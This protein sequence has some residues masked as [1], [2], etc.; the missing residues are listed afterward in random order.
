MADETKKYLIN[1]EDNLDEY[2]KRAK[3]AEQAVD[4]FIETNK[5]LLA[6]ADRASEEYIKASAQLKVLQKNRTDASKTVENAVRI[7]N[8]EVGSYQ[9]L[10]QAWKN[11]QTQLK[12]M[13]NAF[14]VNANGVRTLSQ[15]YLKQKKV[16][17]DAKRG[18]DA[19]GKGVAD[20]R[21][22][23]GNYSEAIE[24]A[25]G[26]LTN[27]P[28]AAGNAARGVQGLATGFKAVT[29]ASPLIIITLVINALN[30][31][32]NIFKSLDPILEKI[33][34]SIAAIKAVFTVL[35]ESIV[36]LVT[37]NKSLKETFE[38]LG[39]A[40][41][42]AAQQGRDLKQAEQDL[43]NMNALLTV[44]NAKTKR[45][46][47]ELILQ[48]KDRTKTEEERIQLINQAL[49]AEEVQYEKRK[50]V[51]DKELEIAQ[52][53]IITGRNLTE[54]QIRLLEEQGIAYAIQLQK[55]KTI[56]DEEIQNLANA[57]AAEEEIL[58]E[59]VVIREKAINRQNAL[60]D[61]Q[62][63][64][65]Q[66]RIAQQEKDAE[67]AK[68]DMEKAK[69]KLTKE[70]EDYKQFIKDQQEAD[71]QA[72]QLKR[73]KQIEQAEWELNQ[74]LINQENLLAIREQNNE[75]YFSIERERLRMQQEAEIR[76][77][78][79]TGASVAIINQKYKNAQRQLD[80]AEVN[81]KL[82]LYAGFAG[83]L[84]QI[85]GENTAIGKAA[86]IAQTTIATY[87]SAVEA[88]KSLAGIPVVGPALGAVAA[89]AAIAAGIANVK[90]IIAVKSGLPGDTG[91]GGSVP[92]PTAISGSVP[93]QR[94]TAQ[95]VG[96]TVLTQP[97]LTQGQVNALPNQNPL[98]AQDIADA[99]S[100]IP[101][102]VV[103][104]EDIN[105]RTESVKKVEV[106]AT[107]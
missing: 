23:V 66:K 74:Q 103:T 32:K 106:R 54:E 48:S 30:G 44:S 105:A 80:E 72:R 86:A 100:K 10:Y 81:A 87:Q 89:G 33:E 97:T 76:S 56:S 85:F 2:A 41:A 24:G 1:V 91:G 38:G 40:M 50:E 61:K 28:G 6:S 70:L 102:P 4:R 55:T 11:A 96:S 98:T 95:Q 16:V 46:I 7:Q 65:R 27:L 31:L 13:P 34:R 77:A 18:L 49:L 79:D 78:E 51:A 60:L 68:Q 64:E 57:L 69:E 101:A 63:E 17:E 36:G 92:S 67:K 45:Q 62:E 39:D 37:G 14:T 93:A 5:D 20:N 47:D 88:F 15:E 22:N 75:D 35:R 84:A 3:E 82:S 26:K 9:Q 104:V 42:T 90:K 12:L 21:L 29:A 25:L 58:N 53:K 99:V 8:A 73:E 52:Q 107:I 83:N 71:E 94:L 59:S 19:F 43:E